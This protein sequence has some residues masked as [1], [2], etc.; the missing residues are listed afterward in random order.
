MDK[1]KEL[2]LLNDITNFWN[3]YKELPM[4]HPSELSELS[5]I[6]YMG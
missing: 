4:Q 5:P 3:R 6:I 2:E 1:P